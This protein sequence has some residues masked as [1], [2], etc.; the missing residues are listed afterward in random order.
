MPPR[1]VPIAPPRAQPEAAPN[2]SP[3]AAMAVQRSGVGIVARERLLARLLE[4]RRL[5]CITVTGPA[6]S[7][8]STLIAAW[9]QALVPLGT[10]VAWFTSTADD[11]QPARFLDGLLASVARIDPALVGEAARSRNPTIES[12]PDGIERLAISLVRG[13]AA[14]PRDLLLVLDDVHHLT[15]PAIQDALQ[16]LLD[17]APPNLHIVLAS[18]GAV[19]LSLDRLRSQSQTLELD[20]RDLRLTPAESAQYLKAQLGDEADARTIRTLH[21]LSDGWV[22]GLR[23]FTLDWKKKQIEAG[24]AGPGEPFARL[25]AR[26]ALAV[27]QY[28]EQEV[29]SLLAPAELD[30]LVRAAACS[31][32]CA[33]L[34]AALL[35]TP[36]AVAEA[37][38]LLTRLDGNDLFVFPVESQSPEAWYRLHPLLRETLL[39]RFAALDPSTRQAVHARAFAW[40]RDKGL[41]EDAVRHAVQAGQPAQAAALIDQCAQSLIVRGERRELVALLHQMPPRQIEESFRMRLWLAR[42]QFFE[43]DTD[44]CVE[45]LDGLARDLP[46]DSAVLRFHLAT[47]QAALAVQRDDT[48]AA[49]AIRPQLLDVPPDAEPLAVGARNN[50]LSWLHTQQG[51]YEKARRLLLDAPTLL[52]DGAPLVASAAG[53]LQGRCLVGLSYALE[54]RMTQAERIFR[55]VAAEAEQ[56]GKACADAWYLALSLLSDVLYELNDA[57]QALALLE[58]KVDMLERIAMPDAVLRVYRVLAAANWQAGN[59]VAAFAHV[60]RLQAYG[61][62]NQLDR[63]LAHGLGD[64]VHYRLLLGELTAAEAAL[65]RLNAIEARHASAS[66]GAPDEIGEVAQRARIRLTATLGDFESAASQLATL[67]A[68]CEER[69]RQR[70]VAHLLVKSAAVDARLGRYGPARQKLLDA[71]RRGHRLGL[72]RSL[73]D[74]DPA[75]RTMMGELAQTESLDPVLAFYVERLQAIRARPDMPAAEVEARPTLRAAMAA[76]LDAFSEREIEM[77]RLLAQAKPNKKI[78]R[79]LGLSPETVKWYLSRIY[80]KLRVAGR[81]EAVARVRDLGWDVDGPGGVAAPA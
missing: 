15:H 53:S 75:A 58:N 41:L 46:A 22:A 31:R 54:G 50:I 27:T 30:L 4:A 68:Q 37:S 80:S 9:R 71:L 20:Q 65:A 36:E 10:D 49:L 6:G 2:G 72:L 63:L 3:G 17:Y 70:T 32:F 47:L 16:W 56:G 28:F 35:D 62:R 40:F 55:A 24:R 64:E 14:H 7:G 51:E 38:A 12:D 18:R 61:T 44:A 81:D 21:D 42:A 73:I 66:S 29:L 77:L 52:V 1:T 43:R 76:D 13:I 78:A 67:I 26:D 11:N 19:R 60:D 39:A 33:P 8:K 59:P 48:A 25:P 69:G 74:A 5:R 45:T 23:L 57:R 79:A 34:C